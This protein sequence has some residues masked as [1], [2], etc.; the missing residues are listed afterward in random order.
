M[1]GLFSDIFENSRKTGFSDLF[2]DGKLAEIF[3]DF[4]STTPFVQFTCGVLHKPRF[5][6]GQLIQRFNEL[7]LGDLGKLA[8]PLVDAFN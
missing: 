2:S 1:I 4:E 7:Y 3:R 5:G 6:A 8:T